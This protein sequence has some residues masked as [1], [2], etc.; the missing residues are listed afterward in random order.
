[1]Q[2]SNSDL[3]RMG[4]VSRSTSAGSWAGSDVSPLMKSESVEEGVGMVGGARPSVQFCVGDGGGDADDED[5]G[6]EGF[7]QKGLTKKDIHTLNE[8]RRRDV[9]RNG[10]TQLSEMVPSCRPST[11]GAKVS[12]AALLQKTIDYVIYLQNQ[13][14]KQEEQLENL[15]KEVKA[16]K[17]MKENY[18]HISR[19]Q[20]HTTG[21]DNSNVPDHVKFL[22]FQSISDQLFQSFNSSISVTSFETLS[23][24]TISWLE[25]YCKPQSLRELVISNLQRVNALSSPGMAYLTGPHPPGHTN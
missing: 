24:C 18:E 22:V 7:D 13:S 20:Q 9:I 11:T 23:A 16:L 4:T 8:Q 15:E 21:A 12:R 6:E 17:I 25:E 3:H 5:Y 19:A 2:R 14:R 1:M 10:Y